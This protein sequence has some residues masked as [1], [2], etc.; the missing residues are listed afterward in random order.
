MVL[1]NMSLMAS[2]TLKAH[3]RVSMIACQVEYLD[4]LLGWLA[5]RNGSVD[6]KLQ[7]LLDLERIG[8][9]GHSRGAKL[10][11]LHFAGICS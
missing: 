1:F 4:G 11:A 7:G 5:E 3:V 2:D 10:A 6:S 8:V 9:A